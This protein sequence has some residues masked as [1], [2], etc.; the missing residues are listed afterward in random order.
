M[1]A[2]PA[3]P[4][5]TRHRTTSQ[6]GRR[7]AAV[8]LH[9][10]RV[11][12]RLG[13]PITHEVILRFWRTALPERRMSEVFASSI[14]GR[15]F[16]YWSRPVRKGKRVDHN[17]S[18]TFA[19]VA[20]AKDELEVGP[21]H[22]HIHWCLHLRP[23]NEASFEAGLRKWVKRVP[24]LG[25]VPFE[26]FITIREIYDF[27]RYK[28]YLTKGTDPRYAKQWNII[29]EAQGT[30]TGKRCGVSAN[31]SRAARKSLGP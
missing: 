5:S 14:R 10:D 17:G 13:R 19:W 25:T 4:G 24:E 28:L 12:N 18:P 27:R 29:S 31:L 2:A 9:S 22:F 20:E 1:A 23:G 26:D 30:I 16:C 7:P 3:P 21:Q 6:I 8:I 11:A 15:P